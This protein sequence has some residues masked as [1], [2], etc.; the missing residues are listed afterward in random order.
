MIL[1]IFLS[2]I[3]LCFALYGT[4]KTCSV[5]CNSTIICKQKFRYEDLIVFLF[6]LLL[7]IMTAFR[8]KQ[9]GNDTLRYIDF[10]KNHITSSFV[11]SGRT[12]IGFQF[13]CFAIGRLSMNPHVFLIVCSSIVYIGLI[14]YIF[15]FC[16]NKSLAICLFYCFFFSTFMSMIRQSIA[17]VIVLYAYQFLKRKK[18]ILFVVLVILASLFH[19]TALVTLLLLFHRFYKYRPTT[20][21]LISA[22][23]AILSLFGVFNN[24]YIA[25]L[26]KYSSY[27]D[28]S[29]ASSGF[30]AVGYECVRN[31]ALYAIAYHFFK[32]GNKKE[33]NIMAVFLLLIILGVFGFSMNLFTRVSEYFILIAVIEFSN[34]VTSNVYLK[35]KQ[36]YLRILCISLISF[37]LVVLLVR[38]EWN[39][40]SPYYFW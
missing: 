36:L 19:T 37:F 33:T 9:I 18:I 15:L 27:F 10:F 24:F 35:N 38:P 20:V 5:S 17:M 29:Y 30:L 4:R 14:I 40:I 2:L 21:F 11:P 39:N 28:S 25:I 16:N 3:A 1:Y 23:L 7:W 6:F 31:V 34:M 22:V 32:S 8:A 26:P 12:E 13:L